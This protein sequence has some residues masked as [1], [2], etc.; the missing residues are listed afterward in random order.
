MQ[1]EGN[2]RP[3]RCYFE[4]GEVYSIPTMALVPWRFWH[5]PAI[6]A[7]SS[8][9]AL[10]RT[11]STEALLSPM[12]PGTPLQRT[13]LLHSSAGSLEEARE[14][15]DKGRDRLGYPLIG[16]SA[17]VGR[18][19]SRTQRVRVQ[20]RQNRRSTERT[21]ATDGFGAVGVS[22]HQLRQFCARHSR[23]ERS[24]S[25][26]ARDWFRSPARST[27]NGAARC[28]RSSPSGPGKGTSPHAVQPSHF[29]RR[30]S[31]RACRCMNAIVPICT[32]DLCARCHAAR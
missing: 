8:E 2:L 3:Q 19:R 6:S 23:P 16:R 31:G 32:G 7:I 27:D 20:T 18:G 21:G 28:P 9:A 13:G 15:A 14:Y 30:R 10:K 25:H 11:Q 12:D 29:C 22:G 5:L 4:R 26:V 17:Q 24:R 1:A